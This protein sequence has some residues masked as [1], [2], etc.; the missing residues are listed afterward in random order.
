MFIGSTTPGA[1]GGP[2]TT[3]QCY[4]VSMECQYGR[5]NCKQ[6]F[7]YN[8]QSCSKCEYEE[9]VVTFNDLE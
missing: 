5:C 7:M 3:N 9:F 2:C 8:G 6:G 4:D 1:Y